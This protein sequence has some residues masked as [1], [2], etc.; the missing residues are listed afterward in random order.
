MLS[1]RRCREDSV[2]DPHLHGAPCRRGVPSIAVR[3]VRC[4]EMAV[5]HRLDRLLMGG[6][7]FV[8]PLVPG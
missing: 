7:D 8:D 1:T 5:S 4:L 2:A 6:K 3:P